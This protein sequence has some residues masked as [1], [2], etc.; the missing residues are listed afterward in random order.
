MNAILRPHFIQAL[1]QQFTRDSVRY[2]EA[3]ACIP[4]GKCRTLNRFDNV[5]MGGYNELMLFS[6]KD[7]QTA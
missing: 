7:Y 2:A 1:G 6:V 5:S 3:R 4:S